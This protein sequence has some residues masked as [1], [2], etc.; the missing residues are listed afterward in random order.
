MAVYDR[1][2]ASDRRHPVWHQ[3]LER[4]D[5]RRHRETRVRD[6]ILS[7][8]GVFPARDRQR[9]AWRR[10]SICAQAHSTPLT[11]LADRRGDIALAGQYQ[12]NL[13]GGDHPNPEYRIAEFEGRHRVAGGF[14]RRC[15]VGTQYRIPSS[16]QTRDR[17]A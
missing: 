9:A 1:T 5:L 14:R 2:V 15:D 10:T 12:L 4:R 7:H 3:R 13:V 16:Q 6:R 11:R 8:R 17:A